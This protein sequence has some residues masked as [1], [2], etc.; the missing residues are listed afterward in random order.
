MIRWAVLAHVIDLLRAA[1]QMQAVA[2]EQAYPGDRALAAEMVWSGEIEGDVGIPVGTGGRKLRDDRFMIPLFVRVSARSNHD[3]TRQRCGD[4][5][6]AIGDVLADD[7][8][9]GDFEVDGRGH[10]I[11]AELTDVRDATVETPSDGVIAFG[12]AV[13]TVHSRLT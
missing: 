3:E 1:P 9:L 7:P 6:S 8:T 11:S 13:L 10:V 2:V 5:V 4:L 12:Q